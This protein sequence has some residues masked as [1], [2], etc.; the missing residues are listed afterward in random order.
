MRV[1]VLT[2][3]KTWF[4]KIKTIFQKEKV[5]LE[6]LYIF[7]SPKGEL[8]FGDEI[9]NG[10]IKVLDVN[11]NV[12][13]LVEN[14]DLGFSC[15]CKQIFSKKLVGSIRCINIHPGLNPY[16]RGWFPQ[17]FSII[18]G[19]PSGVTIHEM[20]EIVDHGN[21]IL[22][23]EIE[24]FETDT[25]KTVYDKIIDE[26]LRLFEANVIKLVEG[27]YDSKAMLDEGNYNSIQDYKNICHIDLNQKV[28]MREA[29][30]LLRALTHPPHR[31]AYFISGEGEKIYLSIKVEGG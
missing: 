7:C 8:I 18:N 2:D 10:K 13:Y 1:F 21:I 25:S 15:H 24:I 20:D 23:K 12:D 6:S 3:N 22:Q 26:E 19:L 11:K 14:F 29:I 17:V 9:K 28:T 16:N 27:R 5:K 4:K 30:N 31:N